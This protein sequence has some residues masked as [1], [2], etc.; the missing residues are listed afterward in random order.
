MEVIVGCTFTF[1][2]QYENQEFVMQIIRGKNNDN[3]Q[4]KN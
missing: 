4:N 2:M 3:K 1:L